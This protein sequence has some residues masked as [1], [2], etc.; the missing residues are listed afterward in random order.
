MINERIER[1]IDDMPGHYCKS[2]F[3]AE[4]VAM[5]AASKGMPVIVV[6]PTVPIGPGDHNLTPPAR[7][8]LGFLNGK[9]PAVLD[10]VLNMVD[11][12]DAARGHVLA[13]EK[14]RPG[15]RYILAGHNLNLVEFLGHLGRVSGLPMPNRKVP[16]TVALLYACFSEAFANLTGKPPEAPITGVRLAKVPL[17][18]DNSRAREELGWSVRPLDETL[19][20]GIRWFW[21]HGHLQRQPKHLVQE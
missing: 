11:G 5:E 1:T 13:E 4:Q 19:E 17:K 21:E 18:I 16:Y 10:S 14:G 2:K 20:D 7:M 12:R 6:N 9:H 15:E 3:L 8:Q